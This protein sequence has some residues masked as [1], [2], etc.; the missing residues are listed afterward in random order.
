MIIDSPK[1][2]PQ[3]PGDMAEKTR[4][5][6]FGPALKKRREQ[7]NLNP[8][9]VAVRAEISLSTYCNFEEGRYLP[10]LPVYRILC[11]VLGISPGKLLD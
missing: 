11:K 3:L 10:S 1:I 4:L 2:T 6:K 9:T 5:P 8:S 7:L